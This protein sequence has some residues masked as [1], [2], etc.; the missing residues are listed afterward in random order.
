MATTEFNA[1]LLLADQ[2]PEI[3]GLIEG[4]TEKD[5]SLELIRLGSAVPANCQGYV[6]Q[7]ERGTRAVRIDA[8]RQLQRHGIEFN[9]NVAEID[10]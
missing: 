1:G 5:R 6:T 3:F 10:V 8:M 2:S 9:T 7:I 4:Y